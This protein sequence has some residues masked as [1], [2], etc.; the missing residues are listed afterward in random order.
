MFR[1]TLWNPNKEPNNVGWDLAAEE[2]GLGR[3]CPVQE[4]DMFG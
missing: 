3:T 2:L 1:I 4:S